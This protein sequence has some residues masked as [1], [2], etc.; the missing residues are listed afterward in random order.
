MTTFILIVLIILFEMTLTINGKVYYYGSLLSLFNDKPL[1]WW[2]TEED[3]KI[4]KE[5][6]DR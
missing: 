2:G 1:F 3:W 5:T 4:E 6:H